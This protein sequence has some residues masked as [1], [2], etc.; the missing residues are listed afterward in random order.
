MKKIL[1]VKQLNIL[2]IFIVI[3]YKIF[4][5]EVYIYKFSKRI[6]SWH[7]LKF[8]SLQECNF[9]ECID[10]DFNYYGGKS[11][12][13]ID[14]VVNDLTNNDLLENFIP[15]LANIKDSR[16]KHK[17]LVKDYILGRCS[18]LSDIYTWA[19][20]YFTDQK[21]NGLN[22]YLLGDVCKIGAHFLEIRSS[23]I[24]IVPVFSSNIFIVSS[25]IFKV[26]NTLFRKFFVIISRVVTTKSNNI[27]QPSFISNNGDTLLY[28]I[29]YF[30]HKS[31]FYGDLFV[32]D[33]FYSTRVDSEF[34]PSNILHVELEDVD[35]SEKQYK[36]YRD[37]NI[38]SVILP[39]SEI[40]TIYNS[41]IY[42]LGEIGLKKVLFFIIKDFVLFFVFV[43]NSVRLLSIKDLI[44]KNYSAK[45]VLVGYDILFPVTLSLVFESLKIRTVSVQERFL[46]TFFSHFSFLIDTYLCDSRLVCKVID[47][48]NDKFV[49]SC[50]PCGQIRSDILINYQKNITSKNKRFTIVAFDYHSQS[51]FDD[52]RLSVLIN[53]KANANFYKD[54][55]NLAEAFPQV[56]IIIRGKNTDWTKISYFK[57]V[58][59]KVNRIPNIWIDED[60][61]KLNKQYELASRSDLII[62]KPTSIGDE[63]MAAGKRVVYY[64]YIPNSSHYFAS[65]YF[66]YNN[67][68]IFA[69]SYTQLKQM[70]QTIVNGG[71]LLT[72]DE[73]LELQVITNNMPADGN[74]KS[75]V[76]KN[77]NIIYNQACL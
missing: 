41:L 27:R 32:K 7:L 15:F 47:K 9:E 37:N 10:I 26:L 16:K 51:N 68:N 44:R 1:V 3:I 55:C 21:K 39:K 22:V 72:D 45:L 23:N 25:V 8:L 34:Y 48:S 28:K 59:N 19:N 56:D 63:A 2:N 77:L 30:P 74:V 57:N 4:K 69:Y 6:E 40:K 13:A 50:L 17:L 65:G 36:Y 61:S 60:Y 70:V 29:L 42:I 66:N 53:W 12:D 18:D 62:A 43:L 58:L 20:G 75:R 35:I 71:E 52:N 54:L 31:I 33:I 49:N 67:C 38:T 5:F 64:D 46:P 14:K 24:K 11:G 73:V 76:M